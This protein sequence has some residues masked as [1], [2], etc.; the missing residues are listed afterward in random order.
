MAVEMTGGPAYY[1]LFTKK[2]RDL[3]GEVLTKSE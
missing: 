3:S 2:K 1:R